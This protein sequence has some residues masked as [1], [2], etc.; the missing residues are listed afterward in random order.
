MAF[1]TQELYRVKRELGY[2]LL[3]VGSLPYIGYSALFESV[4]NTNIDAEVATT[5]TL[6]TAIAAST[7][8]APQSLTLASATGFSAGARVYVDV[9][10][11]QELATIGSLT[12]SVISVLLGKAHAG[13]I[14]VALEGPIPIAR[15]ILRK[16]ED[17]R[18]EMAR[19]FG[20]GA[21]R[22]VDEVEFFDQRGRTLFG[23]LGEQ[24]MSWRDELASV[25][26]VA[27]GWRVARGGGG[28]SV[29][30]SVY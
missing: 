15:D 3:T 18:D 9:D 4:I 8:P 1:S 17:V 7:T 20:D 30:V 22:K 21:I 23:S 6:A 5:A 16:I 11:R 2:H 27:N 10:S 13:T 28:G 12:G 24:L 26:G 14:P 19:T 29:A 25:L